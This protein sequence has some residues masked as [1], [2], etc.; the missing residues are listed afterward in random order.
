LPFINTNEDRQIKKLQ[1]HPVLSIV[2]KRIGQQAQTEFM[3]TFDIKIRRS[4]MLQ[5]LLVKEYTDMMLQ[6]ELVIRNKQMMR[7]VCDT[8]HKIS[9]TLSYCLLSHRINASYHK[10]MPKIIY[11]KNNKVEQH[12]PALSKVESM[13]QMQEDLGRALKS[14]LPTL[15]QQETLG[16]RKRK[17]GYLIESPETVRKRRSKLD[18]ENDE[19]VNFFEK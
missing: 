13:I 10:E 9:E 5:H 7:R 4:W 19:E 3:C 11:L 14:K 8:V 15:D 6:Y 17:Q 2:G 12:V 18:M 16:P 1:Q